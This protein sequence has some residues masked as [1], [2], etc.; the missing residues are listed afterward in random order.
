MEPRQG[1]TKIHLQ[2]V[3]NPKPHY[4]YKSLVGESKSV[5]VSA[6]KEV[7]EQWSR[8][9]CMLSVTKRKWDKKDRR[10]KKTTPLDKYDKGVVIGLIDDEIDKLLRVS[11]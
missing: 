10:H 5:R 2:L 11:K 1:E 3:L 9:L 4:K 6:L 8:V 7:D